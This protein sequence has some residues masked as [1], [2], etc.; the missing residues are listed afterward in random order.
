MQYTSP[1]PVLALSVEPEQVEGMGLC[2]IGYK[3]Q[4]TH[5]NCTTRY[6]GFAKKKFCFVVSTKAA[7]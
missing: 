7:H 6:T 1:L 3:I 4:G 2:H 5:A